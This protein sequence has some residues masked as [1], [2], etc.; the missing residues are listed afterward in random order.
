MEGGL[1]LGSLAHN[2]DGNADENEATAG[3][4]LTRLRPVLLYLENADLPRHGAQARILAGVRSRRKGTEDSG[5]LDSA[6]S[7]PGK[8]EP[9]RHGHFAPTQILLPGSSGSLLC[10]PTP[11]A[12]N[13]RWQTLV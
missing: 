4:E 8:L 12:R 10:P 7:Q 13:H 11:G 2:A 1:A 6:W 5:Y 9:E 3:R